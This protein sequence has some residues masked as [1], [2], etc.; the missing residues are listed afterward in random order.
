MRL[1]PT[2]AD[3]NVAVAVSPPMAARPDGARPRARHIAATNPYPAAVPGPI[4]WRPGIIGTRSDWNVLNLRR[5]REPRLPLVAAGPV[6]PAQEPEPPELAAN[7]PSGPPGKLL[8]RCWEA[9]AADRLVGR[10]KRVERDT[11]AH[12]Q[13]GAPR[14]RLP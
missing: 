8:S 7:R 10:R 11:P 6:A 1:P 2:A 14:S 4:T 9:A 12:I 3:P 5:R 13:P